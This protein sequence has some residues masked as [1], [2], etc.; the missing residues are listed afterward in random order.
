MHNAAFAAL[1]LDYCYVPL[2]VR[3][4]HLEAAM[5]G[6]LALRFAGANVTIPHKQS[7]IRHVDKISEEAQAIGAINTIVIHDGRTWGHNTDWIGF[8]QVL[9]DVGFDPQRKQAVVLGAGGAARAVVYALTRARASVV[10]VNRTL[11]RAEALIQHFQSQFPQASLAARPLTEQIL[12][13]H[14]PTAHLFVNATPVGMWPHEEVSPLP[15][16]LALRP[17]AIIF[18]LLYNP[19]ETGLMRQ[20]R[21]RKTRVIGGLEMLVY[22]GA[23]AFQLWT[24]YESPV[25]VMLRAAKEALEC[26]V[27]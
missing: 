10:V 17:D 2:P 11:S 23:E 20:A 15:E 16:K 8:A 18:D 14:L 9:R 22:Q 24:G 1:G 5:T 21:A 25:K 6:L 7:V 19:E 13:D 27:S 3:P 4:G 12:M 26:C